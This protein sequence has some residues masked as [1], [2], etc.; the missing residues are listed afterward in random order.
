MDVPVDLDALRAELT[1]RGLAIQ[2]DRDGSRVVDR[3]EPRPILLRLDLQKGTMLVEPPPPLSERQARRSAYQEEHAVLVALHRDLLAIA[4]LPPE[5]RVE[6]TGAALAQARRAI[7]G[8]DR[9]HA[10]RL[11]YGGHKVRGGLPGQG[12]RR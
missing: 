10:S 9:L 1:R 11:T 2:T 8:G 12:K 4:K 6:R 5:A 3:A 7:Q